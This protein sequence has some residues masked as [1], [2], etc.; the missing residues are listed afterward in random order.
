MRF[1][2]FDH[3][4]WGGAPLD[5]HFEDRLALVEAYDRLG[6]HGYHVA[7]H[8]GTPHRRL[9]SIWPRPRN[10]RG[11]FGSARS[12]ISFHSTIRSA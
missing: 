9:R 12:S 4:D 6:F 2:V 5:R 1:G 7:E 10:A 8:H 11:G 3:V